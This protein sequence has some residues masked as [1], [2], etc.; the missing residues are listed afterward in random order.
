MIYKIQPNK[1]IKKEHKCTCGL[2]FETGQAPKKSLNYK[3][4]DCGQQFWMATTDNSFRVGIR[5][6]F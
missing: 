5:K 3:C 1:E 4:S 6:V 2:K